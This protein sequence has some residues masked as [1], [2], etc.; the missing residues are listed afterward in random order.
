[1]QTQNCNKSNIFLVEETRMERST[2]SGVLFK[3]HAIW[4]LHF[5]FAFT[6]LIPVRAQHRSVGLNL[7]REK[8]ALTD[9]RAKHYFILHRKRNINVPHDEVNRG[10]PSIDSMTGQSYSTTLDMEVR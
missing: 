6:D 9:K 3:F 1:M 8:K 2:L 4:G 10:H 5:H 7:Q